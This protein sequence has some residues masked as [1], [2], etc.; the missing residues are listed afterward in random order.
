MYVEIDVDLRYSQQSGIPLRYATF[1]AQMSE[2]HSA[3]SLM[4]FLDLTLSFGTS[5][6]LSICLRSLADSRVLFC[7]TLGLSLLGIMK[8]GESTPGVTGVENGVK[9]GQGVETHELGP[10]VS[11]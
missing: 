9:E 4:Q 6:S 1:S 7:V 5:P 10:Q 3:R 11:Q 8:A 2:L